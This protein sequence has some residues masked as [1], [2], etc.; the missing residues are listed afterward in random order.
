MSAPD[1]TIWEVI[2]ME[3]GRQE[4]LRASGKFRFTIADT[5]ISHERRL[6]ILLEEVG[7]VAKILNESDATGRPTYTLELTS[8]LVQVAACAVGW[9]EALGTMRDG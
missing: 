4:R 8:E 2:L 3:R 9:L 6:T 1:R 5:R 7:E